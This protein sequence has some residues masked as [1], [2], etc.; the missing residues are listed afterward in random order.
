MSHDRSFDRPVRADSR[1]LLGVLCGHCR[2][3]KPVAAGNWLFQR[4]H[5]RSHRPGRAFVCSFAAIGRKLRR[6]GDQPQFKDHQ[7]GHS[8][9]LDAFGAGAAGFPQK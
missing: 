6:P 8:R 4:G 1:R 2:L 9:P 5:W 3:C 7:S